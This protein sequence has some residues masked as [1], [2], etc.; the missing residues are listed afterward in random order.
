M[1]KTLEK[2]MFVF[3]FLTM[4][5]NFLLLTCTM[6]I[7]KEESTTSYIVAIVV[8]VSMS[9]CFFVW[10]ILLALGKS[11]FTSRWIKAA[12][13]SGWA[14]KSIGYMYF[15]QNWWRF[16]LHGIAA[17]CILFIMYIIGDLVVF[18]D[19]PYTIDRLTMAAQ[20]SLLFLVGVGM[21]MVVRYML[22]LRQRY[23]LPLS[24]N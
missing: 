11:F 8:A 7:N 19:L 23:G 21:T 1:K 3:G 17:G 18:G 9:M 22:Y 2:L 13:A 12:K 16:V 24:K 20:F 5:C 10:P 6:W 14:A 4:T 15:T